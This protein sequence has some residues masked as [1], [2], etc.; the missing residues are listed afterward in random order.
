MAIFGN[1]FVKKLNA[2]VRFLFNFCRIF[3]KLKERITYAEV[4]FINRNDFTPF[5]Y[6]AIILA[7][8]AKEEIDFTVCV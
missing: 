4:T 3:C 2:K 5:Q 1:G 6:F 7:G 8:S